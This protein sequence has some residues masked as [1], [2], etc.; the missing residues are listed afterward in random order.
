MPPPTGELRI[1]ETSSGDAWPVRTQAVSYVGSACVVEGSDD[2][3]LDD[4]NLV[5]RRFPDR[6]VTLEGDVITAWPTLPA[7]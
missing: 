5:H 2:F 3:D 4:L 6:H 7:G 1:P